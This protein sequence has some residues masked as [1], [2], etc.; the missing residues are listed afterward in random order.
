MFKKSTLITV[1]AV[2]GALCRPCFSQAITSEEADIAY[3]AFYETYVNTSN[4]DYKTF[5][6]GDNQDQLLDFWTYAHA[7]QVV[8]DMYE[9]TRDTVYIRQMKELWIGFNETNWADGTNWTTNDYNDDIAWWIIAATRAYFLTGDTVY[10]TVAKRNYDWVWETQKDDELGG[11]IWWKNDTHQEKNTCINAPMVNAAVHL[12][13]IYD[14]EKYLDHAKELHDWI[15]VTLLRDDGGLSDHIRA[16]GSVRGGP[17]SYNQGTFIGGAY[18]LFKATGDSGYLEDAIKSADYTRDR[19]CGNDGI[20]DGGN[21]T[22]DGAAFN[23][24]FVHH[25]MYFI[26]DGNQTQY[27]DWMTLNA[28]SA[29]EHRRQSDNI[30]STRWAEDP[31]SSG[32]QAPSCA[33]GVALVNLVV[34]AHNPVSISGPGII[35]NNVSNYNDM[36]GMRTFSIN[37]KKIVNTGIRSPSIL[38]QQTQS[39]K[40]VKKIHLR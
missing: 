7:W 8:M 15:K 31:P 6:K 24:V 4:S 25:M 20:L 26:I 40:T 34:L 3:N 13:W 5:Y 32:V 33:G 28:E 37:G 22:G 17:L 38:L 39:G 16:D 36:K 21:Y 1:L 11:G 23:T 14:D 9:R 18:R 12:Y 30:M 29:W 19:M 10:S 2:L 35:I 27:L